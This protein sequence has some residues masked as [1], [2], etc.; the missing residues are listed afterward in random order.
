LWRGGK[1][2]K[3]DQQENPGLGCFKSGGP[4]KRPPPDLG[5]G[6]VGGPVRMGFSKT[7]GGWARAKGKGVWGEISDD[8]TVSWWDRAPR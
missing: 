5:K 2:E 1:G 7:Q 3:S 4:L 8:Q 6:L